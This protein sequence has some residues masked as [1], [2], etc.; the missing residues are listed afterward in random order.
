MKPIPVFL[1]IILLILTA[2]CRKNE[3][4][5]RRILQKGLR[6]KIVYTSCATTVVQVL[7][8]D[9]GTDWTSCT[10]K[11]T[12]EHVVDANIVNRNGLVA[13]VEFSFNIVENEPVFR[14]DMLDCIPAT[15]AT[16]VIT[17]D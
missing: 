3:E 10:D 15:S 14:C 12:Y 7:N 8:K 11:K 9:I 4:G 1:C 17:G 5:G 6:G 16:I 13:E 2:A